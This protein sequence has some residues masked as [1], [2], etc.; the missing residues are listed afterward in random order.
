M[1][2]PLDG[3]LL[4]ILSLALVVFFI[5]LLVRGLI[6]FPAESLE[7]G[8]H[9]AT[10]KYGL[11]LYFSIFI[12]ILEL[13]NLTGFSWQRMRIVSDQELINTAID[14]VYHD[15]YKDKAEFKS[16]YA[17]FEPKA[18]YWGS[19]YWKMD[20]DLVDKLLGF[21]RYHVLLLDTVVILDV[22]GKPLFTR[23]PTECGLGGSGCPTVM[24]DNPEQ[25]IVGTVQL[26]PP[27][28]K[29]AS[30]QDLSIEWNGGK[31]QLK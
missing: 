24:P 27:D 6:L 20:N 12:L 22:A 19:W 26:G 9:A 31:L 2:T 4:F 23:P 25:G 15:I 30:K 5:S 13:A 16:N 10:A 29:P 17:H 14:F 1:G 18:R 7:K 3:V 28:Y 21:T 11:S 8:R